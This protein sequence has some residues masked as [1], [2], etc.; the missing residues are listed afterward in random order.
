MAA[1]DGRGPWKA[2]RGRE[3]HFPKGFN[4]I[5]GMLAAWD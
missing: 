1:S 3:G 2:V 5:I 4:Q